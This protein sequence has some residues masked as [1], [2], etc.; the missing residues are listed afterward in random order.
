MTATGSSTDL[1]SLTKNEL[2]ERASDAD[3]SDRS[4]MTK[5][6]LVDALQRLEAS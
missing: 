1:S 6:E 5:D 4:K 3:V 2:Y